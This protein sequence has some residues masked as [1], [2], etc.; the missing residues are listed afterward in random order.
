LP[1]LKACGSTTQ[2]SRSEKRE[3]EQCHLSILRKRSSL[4]PTSATAAIR[5][6]LGALAIQILALRY[7]ADVHAPRSND[8]GQAATTTPIG[9]RG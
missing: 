7:S 9:D 5:L 6:R 4:R 1:V 8:L 3:I 2:K